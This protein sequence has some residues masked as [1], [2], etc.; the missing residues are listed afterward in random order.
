[1]KDRHKIVIQQT[2]ALEWV[3]STRDDHHGTG[4]TPGK[5]LVQLGVYL[6][7]LENIERDREVG[8]KLPQQDW[9]P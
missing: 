3:A 9:G 4:Q 5:A 2:P 7:A 8:R 6:D 1:M